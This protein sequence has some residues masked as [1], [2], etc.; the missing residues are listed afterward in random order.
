MSTTASTS[1]ARAALGLPSTAA[2]E[3]PSEPLPWPIGARVIVSLAAVS[4]AL[5]IGGLCLL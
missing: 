1:E 5:V 3:R 4:W 2:D